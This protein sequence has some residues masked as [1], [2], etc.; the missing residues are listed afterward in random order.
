VIAQARGG[1]RM[2]SHAASSDAAAGLEPAPAINALH[3][4]MNSEPRAGEHRRQRIG[5][6]LYQP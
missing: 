1:A 3:A 2:L 4:E 6:A 5:C